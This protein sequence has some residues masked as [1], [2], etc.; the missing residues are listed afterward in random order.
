MLVP[1]FFMTILAT[2]L[3]FC[4]NGER[5]VEIIHKADMIAMLYRALKSRDYDYYFAYAERLLDERVRFLMY[6]LPLDGDGRTALH[7]MIR[8]RAPINY[9]AKLVN[10]GADI[11]AAKSD[12]VMPIHTASGLGDESV[13]HCLFSGRSMDERKKMLT[14]ADKYNALPLHFAAK[15]GNCTAIEYL[16][17]RGA[18]VDCE[19]ENGETPVYFAAAYD[20][21]ETIACLYKL[22]ADIDKPAYFSSGF[23]SCTPLTA[24]KNRKK[25]RAQLCLEMLYDVQK[26]K[27]SSHFDAPN[28]CTVPISSGLLSSVLG[29]AN[30]DCGTL[31][32]KACYEGFFHLTDIILEDCR[33]L[34][35]VKGPHGNT[36]LHYAAQNGHYWI[37]DLLLRKKKSVLEINA[38]NEDGDTPLH[39]AVVN[40]HRMVVDLL[41]AHGADA[42]LKNAKGIAPTPSPESRPDMKAMVAVEPAVIENEYNISL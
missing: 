24:A 30:I 22:G 39:L 33:T 11:F 2:Q 25:V 32:M 6:D 23:G 38:Q 16:V 8:Y 17:N 15:C 18:A 1:V 36:A 21:P 41:V 27:K 31:L 40:K 9:I 42:F 12:L 34:V 4:M 10:E 14:V 5:S 7:L 20:R 19:A 29:L 37:I 28:E 13:L 26:I 35:N 3:L